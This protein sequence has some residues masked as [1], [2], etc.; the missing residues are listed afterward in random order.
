MFFLFFPLLT[1]R[2]SDY[3]LTY[4]IN[5]AQDKYIMTDVTLFPV[6][7]RILKDCPSVKAVIL[8]TDRCDLTMRLLSLSRIY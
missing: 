7:Q 8:L 2:L 5:H 4:I 3:E 1:I 6:L